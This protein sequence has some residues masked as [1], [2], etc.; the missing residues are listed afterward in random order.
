MS[1]DVLKF[2][3]KHVADITGP[4]AASGQANFT[5]NGVFDAFEIWRSDTPRPEVMIDEGDLW[6][7]AAPEDVK[8]RSRGR[9]ESMRPSERRPFGRPGIERESPKDW[10]P[11]RPSRF[12]GPPR[13]FFNFPRQE[14]SEEGGE[15]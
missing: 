11:N 14:E 5:M 2:E 8:K 3:A 10:S 15:I 6:Y 1:G 9:A 12:G 13:S 7:Y 4:G